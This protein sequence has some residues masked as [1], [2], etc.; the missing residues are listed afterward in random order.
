MLKA[1]YFDG[2]SARTRSDYPDPGAGGESTVSVTLA[3]ICG[4]DLEMLDGYM[5]YRGVPGHEFVGVVER[6]EAHGTALVGKRVAGEINVGCGR[7][8]RC[9][10]G[11]ERHCPA[12]TVLGIQ[13]R[14]GAFAERLSLPARNLHYVPDSVS[15]EQ[16]V[17]IEPLAAAFEISE[18]VQAAAGSRAA[19]VGDGRLAQLICQVLRMSHGDVTCFGRHAEKLKML[20]RFGISTRL[21]VGPAEERSEEEEEEERRGNGSNNQGGGTADGDRQAFDIVVDASGSVSGFAD[22]M[23]LTR[24]RGTLVLKSTTASG[25]GAD[26]TP[27]VVHEVTLVGSR[28][29]V[30]GPAIEALATGTVQVDHMMDSTFPLDGFGAAVRRSREGDALKV[31]LKP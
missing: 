16:A 13:G 7:C 29:G 17:F 9:Q 22:A 1:V 24:P 10:S 14:D 3:G 25:S 23:Y 19:V 4:T 12:R 8:G 21:N 28:C 15:D 30:F 2:T 31:M 27:A 6:S 11:M 20:E 5:S 26:L 18:Q